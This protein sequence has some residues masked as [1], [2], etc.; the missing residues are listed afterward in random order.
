MSI[1][2]F[3]EYTRLLEKNHVFIR[4]ENHTVSIFCGDFNARS[5]L[6]WEGDSENK[7]GCVFN[8]IL[9]L[10]HLEQFISEPTHVR[11]D[12]SQ[13]CIDLICTDQPYILI[14]TV[15]LSSLDSRSKHNIIHGTI[16]LQELITACRS[17]DSKLARL[18]F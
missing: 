14:D 1:D 6:F 3:I 15:V 18:V 13:S 9:T 8:D 12:V 16:M 17:S 2:E 5:P 7:E 4:K 11:D 10:N